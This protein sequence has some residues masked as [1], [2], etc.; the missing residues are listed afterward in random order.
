MRIFS[1]VERL[2][3]RI[4]ICGMVMLV[5]V[6][7]MMTNDRLR[8]YLSAEARLEGQPVELPRASRE[9]TRVSS[10]PALAPGMGTITIALVDYSALS[11]ARLL[12][13]GKEMGRFTQSSMQL[14]VTSGDL[15]EIDTTG[16]SA[17]VQLRI[18][19][20]SSN[21]TFPTKGDRF[22]SQG[23]RISVGRVMTR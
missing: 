18:T 7:G 13:N 6:Q 14:Y 4:A 16:Y 1:V 22:V 20:A 17:P 12:L 15:I 8:Y 2:A 10:V 9:Q 19:Q 21:L 5:L 3:V 11:N 23:G